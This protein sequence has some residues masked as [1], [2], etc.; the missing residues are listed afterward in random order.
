MVKMILNYYN[1]KK[2]SWKIQ[3]LFKL[4]FNNKFKYKSM[5]KNF[6]IKRIIYRIIQFKYKTKKIFRK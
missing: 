2:K 3:K 1:N 5:L 4:V 6:I